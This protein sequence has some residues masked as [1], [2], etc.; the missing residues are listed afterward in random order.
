M[1]CFTVQ[2]TLFRHPP[3]FRAL[4]KL[5]FSSAQLTTV[6]VQTHT[7][8]GSRAWLAHTPSHT[9]VSE[10]AN[11][12]DRNCV[13]AAE[14]PSL[15]WE[16]QSSHLCS[17]EGFGSCPSRHWFHRQHHTVQKVL[18]DPS[19]TSSVGPD[20]QTSWWHLDLVG[21]GDPVCHSFSLSYEK[22]EGIPGSH[23]STD[24]RCYC[25]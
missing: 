2:F 15:S 12:W 5:H 24:S 10:Q 21:L 3:H 4:K 20:P 1:F 13:K 8:K 23:L 17:E 6:C 18:L 9:G 19:H 22:Q 14:T 11:G 16:V 25:S 7:L